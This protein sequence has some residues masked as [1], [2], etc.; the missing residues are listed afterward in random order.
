[1]SLS[2]MARM[3]LAGGAGRTTRFRRSVALGGED[4]TKSLGFVA[5]G[6]ALAMTV[7][8]A[9]A[10]ETRTVAPAYGQVQAAGYGQYFYYQPV[11]YN[12]IEHLVYSTVGAAGADNEHGLSSAATINAGLAAIGSSAFADQLHLA[13]G[14]A[15]LVYFGEIFSHDELIVPLSVCGTLTSIVQMQ[16]DNSGLTMA[17]SALSISPIYASYEGASLNVVAYSDRNNPSKIITINTTLMMPTNVPFYVRMLADTGAEGG[18]PGL[19]ESAQAS[20]DPYFS[21]D[22]Q[23][24][25]DHPDLSLVLSDGVGNPPPSGTPEPGAWA[26]MLLGLGFSGMS[27]RAKPRGRNLSARS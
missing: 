1:M 8:P 2:E 11:Y 5:A 20:A 16:K 12:D 17:V 18:G 19:Q 25:G 21:I 15:E 6:I 23:Y 26:L 3:L 7:T 14:G 13:I 4:M 27:L 10:S 22:P 9:M 24:L